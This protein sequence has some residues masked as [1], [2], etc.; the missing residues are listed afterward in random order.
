MFKA[1]HLNI[2]KFL[3][4]QTFRNPNK[5][6]PLNPPPG[7]PGNYQQQAKNNVQ[8]AKFNVPSM[9]PNPPSLFYDHQNHRQTH[10]PPT[11]VQTRQGVINLAPL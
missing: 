11:V 9:D 3:E 7:P 10:H 6:I 4:Q 8:G 2:I 1:I 5:V